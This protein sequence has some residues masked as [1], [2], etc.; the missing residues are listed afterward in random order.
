M[1][2]HTYETVHTCTFLIQYIECSKRTDSSSNFHNYL[3]KALDKRGFQFTFNL[4]NNTI[5][6]VLHRPT[7]AM[8]PQ[9]MGLAEG[10]NHPIRA[11]FNGKATGGSILPGGSGAEWNDCGGQRVEQDGTGLGWDQWGKL[12]PYLNLFPRLG[13][14]K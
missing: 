12:P 6:T 3:M 11:V 4:I 10:L 1:K 8:T 13:R 9:Q 14:F 2:L 5:L 7:F